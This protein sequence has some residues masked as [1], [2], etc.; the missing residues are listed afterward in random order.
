MLF[1]SRH[2]DFPSVLPT[3]SIMLILSCGRIMTIGYEK[4]LLLQNNVN[5]S[6]SEVIS[7]YAYNIGLASANPQFSYSAAISLFTSLINMIIL[8]SVNRLSRKISG[9]SLW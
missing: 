9:N 4:V 3:F 2:V 5:T 1:R 7:T 8:F 6:V